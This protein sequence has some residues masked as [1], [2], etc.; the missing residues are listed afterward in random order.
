MAEKVEAL[1]ANKGFLV[2]KA[3]TSE[4]QAQLAQKK[5]LEFIRCS[6]DF[7]PPFT[8]M[9]AVHT[10]AD[11]LPITLY[12]RYCNL[13]SAINPPTLDIKNV[14]CRVFGQP[15][16]FLD[17]IKPHIDELVRGNLNK[18][19]TKYNY[20][21]AHWGRECVEMCFAE[22]EMFLNGLEVESIVIQLLFFVVTSRRKIISKFELEGR[23]R[24]YSFEPIEDFEDGKQ[25]EIHIIQKI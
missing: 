10:A 16:N 22:G 17:Y 21:G 14:N 13:A 24:I 15:I 25:L 2:A 6:E 7:L 11:L 4:A 12:F 19:R 8:D 9:Q 23:G 1:R 18:Y 5:R 3:I 20:S